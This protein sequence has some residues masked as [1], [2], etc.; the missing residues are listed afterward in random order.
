MYISYFL[1]LWFLRRTLLKIAFLYQHMY[2]Q[3]CLLWPHLTSRGHGF[4]KLDFILCQKALMK[5]WSV[6]DE[7]SWRRFLTD[8]TVFLHFCD[9]LSISSSNWPSVLRSRKCENLSDRRRDRWTLGDKKSPLELNAQVSW[10][11]RYSFNNP[12]LKTIIK[13]NLFI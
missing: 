2:K 7:W 6:L 5:I 10:R 4:Q 9:Y 1:A 13:Q 3:F 12:H 11:N 8:P